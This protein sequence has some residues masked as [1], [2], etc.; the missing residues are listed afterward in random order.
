MGNWFEN[1]EKMDIQAERR[2]TQEA[3]AKLA[4]TEQALADAQNELSDTKNKFFQDIVTTI[5]EYSGT[6]EQA[7][8]KLTNQYDKAEAEAMELVEKYW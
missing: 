3:Q 7:V 8:A 5:K 6:K 4:Q 2:N 1:M